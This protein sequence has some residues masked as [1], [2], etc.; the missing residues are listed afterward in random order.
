MHIPSKKK[1]Q[2]LLHLEPFPFHFGRF[3]RVRD[4]RF[5]LRRRSS[6]VATSEST[7]FGIGK[8]FSRQSC[9][10]EVAARDEGEVSCLFPKRGSGEVGENELVM[11]KVRLRKVLL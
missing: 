1:S 2:L 7:G 11:N 3:S 8:L 5:L 6:S 9:P 10:K 4:S